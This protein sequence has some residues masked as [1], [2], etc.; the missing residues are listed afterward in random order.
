MALMACVA[1]KVLHSARLRLIVLACLVCLPMSAAWAAPAVAGKGPAVETRAWILV[2]ALSG[3]V[4]AENQSERAMEPASLTK[5]MSAYL[6]FQALRDGHLRLDQLVKVPE[7][8]WKSEG[9]RMYLDPRQPVS[10]EDL[11]RG[12]I[13]Q[14]G[15]D[16][17]LTL[18]S[19]IA[20]DE[21]GFVDLMNQA[22]LRLGLRATLYANA[23]GL[24]HARHRSTA[25]DLATLAMA[26]QR[27][28]PEQYKY[29]SLKSFTYAG[30][31]QPN[32]NRL[33]WADPN[34]DGLKTGHTDSAGYCLV[35]STRRDQRRLVSVLLGAGSDTARASES[36]KLL[37]YGLEHYDTIKLY[38]AA[39]TVTSFRVYK[40]RGS[41]LHSG[42]LSDFHVTLPKGM[43]A[44]VKAEV[45]ARQPLL[46]PVRKGQPIATLRLKL[47]D[48]PFADYPLVA[49]DDIPVASLLGRIW[50]SL[51]LLFR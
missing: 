42:F 11:I 12:M 44:Q 47:G 51:M 8:A 50:D 41:Q 23:T 48:T 27:D 29:Y 34:V 15:N 14:S 30:I 6:T 21:A 4:L 46:A 19:A 43:S 32:R 3:A 17:T 39:Q 28:F 5:L 2:D 26:L 35:A 31:T 40:G 7:S 49:L 22:A 20:G 37:N 13:V 1:D 10:V 16:A 38:N 33:L 18:A 24:P 9:S 36:L 45:I 25:R